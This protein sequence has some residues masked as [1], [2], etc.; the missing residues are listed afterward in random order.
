MR[1]ITLLL[2][3]IT[4]ISL[5]SIIQAKQIG[6][7][8]MPNKLK[9]ANT[10][11]ILNGAGLREKFFLDLYVGGLYLTKKMKNAVLIMNSKEDM[12]I[13]LHI[14]STLITSKKMKNA[15]MEGF[16]TKDNIIP[17]KKEI[18]KFIAVFKEEI[19]ENDVFEMVYT[20][21][22]GTTILK[23]GKSSA[24][25]KGLKFKKALFGIWLCDDPAQDSLKEDMLGE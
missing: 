21:S 14:V 6:G 19:K 15:T 23:N 17:I 1:K 4:L 3:L 2:T 13:R 10:N 24:I 12:A 5:S 7:I 20:D 22:I 18:N 8:E 16:A 11:L 9:A 25:I